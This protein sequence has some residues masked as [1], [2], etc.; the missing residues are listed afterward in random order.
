MQHPSN[1]KR[2]LP[3]QH[4]SYSSLAF[5]K[6]HLCCHFNSFVRFM[7][8]SRLPLQ[9]SF[10]HSHKY[11]PSRRGKR[12]SSR[13]TDRTSTKKWMFRVK[14]K[15]TAATRLPL[16]S[17][18]FCELYSVNIVQLLWYQLRRVVLLHSM[19]SSQQLTVGLKKGKPS[20]N[21]SSF[22]KSQ[23]SINK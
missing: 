9:K 21:I 7:S 3:F 23:T 19:H 11:L 16:G 8:T 1:A 4:F 14:Q 15:L 5:S 22:P 20:K 2:F 18:G 12:C 13:T 10:G 17:R 6:S